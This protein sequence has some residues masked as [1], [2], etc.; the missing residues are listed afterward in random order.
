MKITQTDIVRE[1]LI[2]L[3]EVGL[4]KLSTRMVAARLGVQQPAIYWHFKGKRELM[5]AMNAAIMRSS[6]PARLPDDGD[7]ARSFLVKSHRS[8]RRALLTYRD[9]A[10]VHAGSRSEASDNDA[11]ERQLAFLVARGLT[12]NLAL[13]ILITLSRFTVGFVMEEQSEAEH[14]PQLSPDE[15]GTHPRL[16]AA[17]ADYASLSQDQ[18]FLDGLDAILDGF[19]AQSSNIGIGPASNATA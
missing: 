5:D 8:F 13:R 1:A 16:T 12:A 14:P 10:R 18:L 7:D 17:F 6:H 19:L 3:N 15:S 4:D 9:G 11:A 2:L